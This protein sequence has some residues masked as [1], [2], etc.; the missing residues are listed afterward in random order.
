MA[1][2]LFSLRVVLFW[3]YRHILLNI[4][5][6]HQKAKSVAHAQ[7]IPFISRF[8]S[9]YINKINFKPSIK[10]NHNIYSLGWPLIS[11]LR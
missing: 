9:V 6:Y 2:L 8:L 4:R 7:R 3:E 1:L 11:R 10:L 5:F